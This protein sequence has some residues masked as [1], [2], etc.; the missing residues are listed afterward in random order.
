MKLFDVQV[1]AILTPEAAS[2]GGK[3]LANL[4]VPKGASPPVGAT[5]R[6]MGLAVPYR[7]TVV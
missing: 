6:Q 7:V 2:L 5:T 4:S 3:I 1:L